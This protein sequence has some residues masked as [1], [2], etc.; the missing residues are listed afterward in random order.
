MIP[1]NDP[2]GNLYDWM[3]Q[4]RT[5]QESSGS[6]ASNGTKSLLIAGL[7]HSTVYKVWVNVTDPGGSGQYARRYYTF[8][9]RDPGGDPPPE[10]PQEPSNKNPVADASARGPYQGYINSMIL[11]DGSR[12]S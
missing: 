1:I 3:I 6:S 10:E 9:T 7:V 8:K 5:G 12:K 11:F 2:D 4:C